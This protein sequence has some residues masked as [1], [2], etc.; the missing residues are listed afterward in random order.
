[1]SAPKN[2]QGNELHECECVPRRWMKNLS[3]INY[4]SVMNNRKITIGSI[5]TLRLGRWLNYKSVLK[6]TCLNKWKKDS[7]NPS[8]IKKL[9]HHCVLD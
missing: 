2:G 3:G 7:E 4:D 5:S 8:N 6:R 9:L 1:M